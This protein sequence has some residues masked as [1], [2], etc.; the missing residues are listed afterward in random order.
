M[1]ASWKKNTIKCC[2]DPNGEKMKKTKGCH[3]PTLLLTINYFIS[4][5]SL[6]KVN[7]QY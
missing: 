1:H 7:M 5:I 2:Y 6:N 4:H 3:N